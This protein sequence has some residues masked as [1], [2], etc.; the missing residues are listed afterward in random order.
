MTDS[1]R[2]HEPSQDA[3]LERAL[4]EVPRGA[5]ALAGVALGLLLLAWL[6]IYLFIFLPR[7]PVS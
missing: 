1:D 5:V 6:A 7:G 3:L 4:A 2:T